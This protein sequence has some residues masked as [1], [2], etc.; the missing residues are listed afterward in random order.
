LSWEFTTP[1]GLATTDATHKTGPQSA[2]NPKNSAMP[3]GDAKGINDNLQ[4]VIPQDI[5]I[6]RFEIYSVKNDLSWGVHNPT[7]VPRLLAD[8]EN[9][10]ISQFKAANYPA[11]FSASSTLT[12]AGSTITFTASTPGT[13]NFGDGTITNASGNT[14]NYAYANP[15]VY[16]VTFTE[17]GG[18]SL[19]RTAY[20]QVRQN[21]T[22]NF[23]S[24][25]VTGQAPLTVTFSNTSSNTNSVEWWRWQFIS[26]NSATRVDTISSAPV[27]F[28]YT[29][30]GTYS[31]LLRANLSGAS[32]VSITKTNYITV[33]P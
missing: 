14:I 22:L 28:T 26:T 7:Y 30:A 6:A 15:G 9:R 23:T 12:Y 5:R 17:P 27:S 24:D 3:G 1:G 8:A 13:W 11:V 32:N 31:V 2:F 33:T 18:K 21:P 16:T 20:I 19:T 25:V 10:V 4:L 29:N